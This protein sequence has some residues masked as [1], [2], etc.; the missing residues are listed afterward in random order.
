MR[1]IP[2]DVTKVTLVATGK[3]AARAEYVTLSDGQRRASG[4]QAVNADGVPEWIVDVICDDPDTAR[5]EV[6]GVRVAAHE[7]PNLPKWQPVR[8]IDLV[9]VPYVDQRSGRVAVSFRAAGIEQA[10]A[11]APKAA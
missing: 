5:T 7:E 8:F 1:E 9:A 6:I 11:A 4:K 2:V 10:K 3:V